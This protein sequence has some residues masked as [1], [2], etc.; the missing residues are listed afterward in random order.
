MTI[1]WPKRP[2]FSTEGSHVPTRASKN[3]G[4]EKV[5][6]IGDGSF[7]AAAAIPMISPATPFATVAF[8]KSSPSIFLKR[9]APLLSDRDDEPDPELLLFSIPGD[10]LIPKLGCSARGWI[11]T[12]MAVAKMMATTP[13]MTIRV[14][15][16]RRI[17]FPSTKNQT[18]KQTR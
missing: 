7:E 8:P 4:L 3:H 6:T 13:R 16:S 1:T 11:L 12:S 15:D 18:N 9:N 17:F 10:E 2:H 5:R 14:S